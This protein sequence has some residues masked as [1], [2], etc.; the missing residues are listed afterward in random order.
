MLSPAELQDQQ[1]LELLYRQMQSDEV[2]L[3]CM[4]DSLWRTIEDQPLELALVALMNVIGQVFVN[5][6]LTEPEEIRDF[7]EMV[8]ESVEEVIHDLV[9]GDSD[10]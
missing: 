6:G 2:H 5:L 4:V 10:V 8:G 7:S 3:N 1:M 9:E